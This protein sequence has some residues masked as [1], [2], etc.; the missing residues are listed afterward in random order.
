MPFSIRVNE[1]KN[2]ITLVCW[3]DVTI[4]EMMEYERR[5]WGGTEHEGFHHIVDLQVANLKIDVNEGLMLATHAT[6]ADPDAYRGARSAMVVGNED[7]RFLVELYRDAR[8]S[9]CRPEIREVGVFEDIEEAKAWVDASV[10]KRVQ[11]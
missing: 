7:Q 8:H 5:Y 2:T 10:V 3:G 9:M 1:P 6:P 11:N 4:E